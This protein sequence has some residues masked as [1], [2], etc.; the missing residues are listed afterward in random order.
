MAEE[1]S[2]FRKWAEKGLA[3][4]GI[5]T[6]GVMGGDIDKSAEAAEKAPPP[7]EPAQETSIKQ[8]RE[9]FNEEYKLKKN[10]NVSVK[11]NKTG[12]IDV[13]IRNDKSKSKSIA[14]NLKRVEIKRLNIPGATEEENIKLTELHQKQSDLQKE[15][16]MAMERHD[17][18]KVKAIDAEKLKVSMEKNNILIQIEKR[19]QAQQPER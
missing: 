19:R 5:A 3:I 18:E 14:S 15:K 12:G 9:K 4:A 1:K 11:I 7:K 13:T 16:I 6:M 17:Q 2:R 10:N 8:Q